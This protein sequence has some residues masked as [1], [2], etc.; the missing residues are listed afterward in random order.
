MQH[1]PHLSMIEKI[2]I[3][4]MINVE[5]FRYVYWKKLSCNIINLWGQRSKVRKKETRGTFGKKKKCL[6]RYSLS[7][8][9]RKKCTNT[10]YF[11]VHIF[12]YS[13]RIQENTDQKKL[14]FGHFSCSVG[15]KDNRAEVFL[16][17]IFSWHLKKLSTCIRIKKYFYKIYGI[18]FQIKLQIWGRTPL[19]AFFLFLF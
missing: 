12:L 19:C 18:L 7:I 11:L 4:S 15:F 8:P 10:V 3:W 5:S 14:V 13:D 16:K 6:I 1:V 17:R 9:L 2:F